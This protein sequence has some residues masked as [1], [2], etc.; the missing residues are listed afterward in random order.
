MSLNASTLLSALLN[1]S[2]LSH[3]NLA[4]P[5]FYLQGIH[6]TQKEQV[7]P[8]GL[9]RILKPILAATLEIPLP[10]N[11]NKNK[12]IGYSQQLSK[13]KHLGTQIL[14]MGK[15]RKL[16]ENNKSCLFKFTQRHKLKSQISKGGFI[17]QKRRS[18]C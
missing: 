15:I 9:A 1:K 6:I 16:T 8:L 5:S 18:P 13:K 12:E 4:Q 11:R 3:N 10:E 7:L 14:H 2:I 17:K